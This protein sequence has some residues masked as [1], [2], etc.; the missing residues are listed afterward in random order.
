M[1]RIGSVSLK[2]EGFQY[3]KAN[4]V[5]QRLGADSIGQMGPQIQNLGQ[6]AIFQIAV[7]F[8]IFK[9]RSSY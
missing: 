3:N 9:V 8:E 1:N 5:F 2:W 6:I 4:R 7:T